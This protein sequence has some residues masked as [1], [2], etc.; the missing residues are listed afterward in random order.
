MLAVTCFS[1]LLS[2][3]ATCHQH[4]LRRPPSDAVLVAA[5]LVWATGHGQVYT[6]NNTP[7]KQK[8]SSLSGSWP[9]SASPSAVGK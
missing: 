9:V 6:F 2:A 7:G 5:Y 8:V 4:Y 1:S 3:A